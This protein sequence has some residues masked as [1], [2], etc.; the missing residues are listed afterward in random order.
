MAFNY[1]PSSAE[2]ILAK[3][4][5]YSNEVAMVFT[6]LQKIYGKTLKVKIT[7]DPTSTFKDVKITR[8]FESKN[9]TLDTVKA[10]LRLSKV[11]ISGL[12]LT[13]GE[14]SAGP[15]TA[16]KNR[17]SLGKALADA[18]EL[19]TIA[20]LTKPIKVP[21][22]TGQAL[23]IKNKDSF[24]DWK[25]TFDL[26]PGAIKTILGSSN[27]LSRYTILHDATDKTT[28]KTAIKN[29]IS[30]AH[31]TKDSW[32]PADIYL[33]ETT[34]FD[35]VVEDLNRIVDELSLQDKLVSTFNSKLYEFY[36]SKL[37]YPIS[38]KQ[39]TNS[40]A[41][42]EYNNLPGLTSLKESNIVIE[43][44]ICNLSLEGQE[45][46][47]FT[48]KNKDTTR[49]IVIQIRARPF[50]YTVAQ[51]EVI[52]DGSP[53]GGRAGSVPTG[54]ID[55][56]LA[57]YG[58]KRINSVGEYFGIKSAGL[59]NKFDDTKLNEVWGWYSKVKNNSKVNVLNE[60]KDIKGLKQLVETAKKDETAAAALCVKIQGLKI[61]YFFI[62]N[63][64]NISAI[65]NK[66]INGAK[67]ISNDNGFFIKIY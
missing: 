45:I 28:F 65:L 48:F 52:S 56:V 29:F 43:R 1:S 66:M 44:F 30:K 40:V 57:E 34:S 23:F 14:G 20:S 35:K 49:N 10:R 18:G 61:M 62:V 25:N 58:S 42:I 24:L 51:T 33:I 17:N 39:V 5:K 55:R 11:D 31:L 32:N 46:G 59:F 15:E 2:D 27:P 7:L 50:T 9:I 47:G 26:T 3:N 63:E 37:V 6:T 67:K 64:K 8:E 60:I 53:S 54:V 16:P 4:K 22:D 36:K 19:A 13:Y 12:N 21:K 41:S 38:L